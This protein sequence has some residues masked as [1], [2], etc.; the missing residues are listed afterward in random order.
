MKCVGNNNFKELLM[1][2]KFVLSENQH[3]K[4]PYIGSLAYC[5]DKLEVNDKELW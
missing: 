2:I 1:H 4:W 5:F 3:E